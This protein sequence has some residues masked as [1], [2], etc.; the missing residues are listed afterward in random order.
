MIPVF[1]SECVPA[2]S[3]GVPVVTDVSVSP[4]VGVLGVVSPSDSDSEILKSQSFC[5]SR[6]RQAFH[7]GSQGDMNAASSPDNVQPV[8]RRRTEEVDCG[9]NQRWAA[10]YQAVARRML[11]Y[12]DNS[13]AS[14]VDIK[15][16]EDH[17]LAPNESRVDIDHIARQSRGTQ[18]KYCSRSSVDKEQKRSVSPM[19]Q[20]G[21]SI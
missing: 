12:L 8:S 1:F 3:S 2:V 17:V 4:S 19:W 20:D 6:K 7:M 9:V 15:E 11:S 16:L 21:G 5:F 14:K 10:V 18:I 13:E